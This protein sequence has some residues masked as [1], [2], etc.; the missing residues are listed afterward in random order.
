M[1]SVAQ[2][3][4]A[5]TMFWNPA[6]TWRNTTLH[7]RSWG[8]VI[9]AY[10]FTVLLVA[11][12]GEGIVLAKWRLWYAG[13]V[14]IMH[15]SPGQVLVF[16]TLR[17]LLTLMMVAA[18]THIIWL[19]REPFNG[20]YNYREAFTLVVA[21]MSPLLL[22]RLLDGMTRFS[23]WVPWGIGLFFSLRILYYG[24]FRISRSH[25]RQVM[26][27][28]LICAGVIIGLSGIDRYIL[29]QCL[30]GHGSSVNNL[31]FDLSSNLPF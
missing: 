21:T 19:L 11:T 16:E 8:F 25:P 5:L 24:M 7:R 9:L 26:D 31:I 10:L 20:D 15:F 13:T 14:G 27:L 28:F 12:V 6:E 4:D 22:C 1:I 18:A 29:I 2:M 17:L 3:V 30:T 23:L